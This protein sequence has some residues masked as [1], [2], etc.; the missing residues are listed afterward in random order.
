MQAWQAVYFAQLGSSDRSAPGRH[1]GI[2]QDIAGPHLHCRA[3]H[4][5]V[6]SLGSLSSLLANPEAVNPCLYVCEVKM[7][8]LQE[9]RFSSFFWFYF[10]YF[11]F[12][13][14]EAI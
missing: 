1:A 10:I 5:S 11:F 13:A 3:C 4:R 7:A 14:R 9:V 8:V 12:L 6:H 2:R